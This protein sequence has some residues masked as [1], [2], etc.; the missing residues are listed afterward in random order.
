MTTVIKHR[1][2]PKQ[3]RTS[4]D[5]LIKRQ[6]AFFTEEYGMVK[7]TPYGEHFI[8]ENPDKSA[9]TSSFLCTCGSVAV[10]ANPY[11]DGR[12]FV[13]LSHAT[14]GFHQ[15]SQVNK[16]DFERGNPIIRKGRKWT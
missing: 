1:G 10:V 2:E 4:Q 15:T 3:A 8:Y 13:C 6:E 11:G 16:K 14:Y 5:I 9:G 7:C 12:T